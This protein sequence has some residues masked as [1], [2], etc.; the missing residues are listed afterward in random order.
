MSKSA[1]LVYHLHSSLPP[2]IIFHTINLLL[3]VVN[4]LDNT[5]QVTKRNGNGE[6]DR[7]QDESEEDPPAEKGRDE[8]KSAG[9]LVQLARFLCLLFV[10]RGPYLEQF[11]NLGGISHGTRLSIEGNQP[12]SA[13]E[14]T[15]GEDESQE[16]EEEADVGSEGANEVD[17]AEEAHEEKPEA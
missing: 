14:E 10:R 8:S 12:V 1:H 7:G 2:F 16:D 5:R 13:G 11:G 9:S 6:I 3:A 4:S 15:K 17:E